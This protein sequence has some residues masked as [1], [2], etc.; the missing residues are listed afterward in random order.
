MLLISNPF[1]K[2]RQPNE[3]INY[4]PGSELR[5]KQLNNKSALHF[6]A[7]PTQHGNLQA[8]IQPR[9]PPS[10]RVL[11]S[12]DYEPWFALT[13]R[14]DCLSDAE[15]RRAL[16]GGFT[17]QAI[18]PILEMLGPAR[19]SFYLVGEIAD[20]YPQ[21]PE[22]ITAAGHELGLHCQT[23][24]PLVDPAELRR[25]LQASAGWRK[26]FSLRG[27]RA[28]MVGISEEAYG[29]LAENGFS[30]SS[31][32]YA[33][34][35]TLLQ[36]GQLWELPVSSLPLFGLT[37]E[38]SAPRHFS[39]GLLLGGEVPYGSSFMIGLMPGMILRILEKELQ[40]GLSPVIILHPYELIRPEAFVRRLGRDL[41]AHPLLF[42]FTLNKSGF[43]K[44]LLRD[45]PVSP[46]GVYL[47]EVLRGG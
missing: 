13:R 17:S 28:P 44:S 18:D 30:Y 29:L 31:S 12:I 35:G 42:P 14:Y 23:H 38:L 27:Y 47:D 34:A 10:P 41:L 24:R 45:F 36:K 39:T 8:I 32:I 11:L 15:Q 4:S 19:A 6:L 37:G 40:S 16:D 2:L 5:R 1:F 9:M 33:P 3:Q 43:L 7:I 20:W 46:L 26:K 25:D 21:V 22:K